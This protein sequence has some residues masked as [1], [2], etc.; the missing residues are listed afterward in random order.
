MIYAPVCVNHMSDQNKQT[1]DAVYASPIGSLGISLDG[2]SLTSL[3]W[4]SGSVNKSIPASK[5]AEQVW[6]CLDAYFES[7]ANIFEL[8]LSLDGTEFQQRTWRALRDISVGQVMT[9]GE[10]A[11]CLNTSSRAIGQACRTNPIVILIPCHRVVA[12]NGIGGYMGDRHQQQIKQWLL[13]HEGAQWKT[14]IKH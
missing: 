8:P 12:A 2:N 7:V 6:H 11:K 3:Q 14:I 10:L 1:F 5:G 4:I 13:A 9:Y